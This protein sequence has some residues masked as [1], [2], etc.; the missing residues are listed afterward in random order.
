MPLTFANESDYDLINEGDD[1]VLENVFAAVQSGKMTMTVNG[2]TI[3]L[4]SDFT[5]RQIDILKAGGLLPY[6]KGAK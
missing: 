3:E 4:V 1:I 2:K 6:T 5:D